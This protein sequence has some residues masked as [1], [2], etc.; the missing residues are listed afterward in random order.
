M[1][2][3][4]AKPTE[5]KNFLPLMSLEELEEYVKK[6]NELLKSEADAHTKFRLLENRGILERA[7]KDY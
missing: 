1:I 4:Y 2:S 6:I 3:P 7:I 5:L